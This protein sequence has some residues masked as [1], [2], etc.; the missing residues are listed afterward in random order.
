MNRSMIFNRTYI[1][2]KTYWSINDMEQP[3]VYINT[4]KT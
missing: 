3:Y 4:V 1:K 2:P